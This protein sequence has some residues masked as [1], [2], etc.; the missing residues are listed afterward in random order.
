MDTRTWAYTRRDGAVHAEIFSS[1]GD[2]P[3][4]WADSPARLAAETQEPEDEA[5]TLRAALDAAGI[6]YDGRWGVARLRAALE[7]AD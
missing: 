4:G 3:E 2:V 7:A 5:A 1:P 6:D